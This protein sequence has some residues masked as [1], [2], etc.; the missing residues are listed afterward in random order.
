MN[1]REDHLR[2]ELVATEA[3]LTDIRSLLDREPVSTGKRAQLQAAMDVLERR[4][5]ILQHL[6]HC[7]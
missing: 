6:L 4:H 3:A 5:Q 7:P 2:N 1:T